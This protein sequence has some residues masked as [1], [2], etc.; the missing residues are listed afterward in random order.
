MAFIAFASAK[1]SPGVTTAVA[2]LAATWPAHRDL[3]VVEIDP[4]GGDLVVRFDLATEPGLVTLA[5]AGRRELAPDTLLSHTQLLPAEATEGAPSRRVLVA[6]VSADQANAS[7]S[8][9][10][11]GL[12]RALDAI[13][14]D[15]LV[16]CGR[17]DPTSPAYEV[18]T[19]AEL[20]IMVARPV[21]AE[22]HHLSSRLSSVKAKTLSLLMVGDRP[23]SVAEVA[24]AVGAS[25]LGSLP[26]DARAASVLTDGHPNAARLLRRSRLLRDAGSVAAGL[27]D[28]LGPSA[29]TGPVVAPPVVAGPPTATRSTATGTHGASPPPPG[30]PPSGPPQSGPPPGRPSSSSPQSGRPPSSCPPAAPPAPHERP[31]SGPPPPPPPRAPSPVPPYPRP[32][33]ASPLPA[34]RHEPEVATVP[35]GSPPQ[36]PRPNDRGQGRDDAVPKHFRRSGSEEPRR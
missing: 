21:V 16:D 7:L 25:A 1:G 35:P 8:A 18:A 29:H 6:P 14:A 26:A 19:G 13:D 17:L 24:E 4:A 34:P 30:P 23:Y 32:A 20:L 11:G 10:R 12:V 36:P 28:W 3:V 15:V 5:A 31:A 9:L 22:V 2:A 33:P 27:A